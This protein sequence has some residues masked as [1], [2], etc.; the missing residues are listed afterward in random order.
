MIEERRITPEPRS[1]S[2]SLVEPTIKNQL[3]RNGESM[4][5]D[6]ICHEFK[7]PLCTINGYLQLLKKGNLKPEEQERIV[8]IMIERVESLNQMVSDKTSLTISDQYPLNKRRGNISQ[9]LGTVYKEFNHF[10][11]GQGHS[12]FLELP[13]EEIYC[14]FDMDMM[15]KVYA[16]LIGNAIKFTP[17]G[18]K[19]TIGLKVVGEEVVTYVEDNGMGLD[20]TYKDWIF[21][22]FKSMN[23]SLKR[24]TNDGY[25]FQ[26]GGSGIGLALVNQLVGMHGG[27]VYMESEGVGKGSKFIVVLKK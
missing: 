18:G 4:R 20:L 24:H 26:G 21:E 2:E 15:Y 12:I 13:E 7:S 25:D 22:P 19:L 6:I 11:N 10:G 14:D 1:P 16:N 5:L 8:N 17:A 3:I 9:L 23:T 27:R